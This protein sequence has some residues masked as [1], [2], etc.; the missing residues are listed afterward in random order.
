MSRPSLRT[1]IDAMCK[2]CLYDPGNG[3]GGWREQVQVCSSTNCPLHPV[4]PLPVN[5]RKSGND[6]HDVPWRPVAAKEGAAA[7]SGAIIGHNDVISDVGR[8]A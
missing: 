1:A 3:N 7:L 8:A 4:R 5:A 6:V 2:N